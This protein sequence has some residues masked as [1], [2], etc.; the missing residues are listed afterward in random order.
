MASCGVGAVGRLPH[1]GKCNGPALYLQG[2]YLQNGLGQLWIE[3]TCIK[4]TSVLNVY[5]IHLYWSLNKN[6]NNYLH[7]IQY[8]QSSVAN[9]I[10]LGG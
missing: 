8:Y 9:L 1:M 7:R 3:A 2:L 5:R 10:H 6:G 4:I